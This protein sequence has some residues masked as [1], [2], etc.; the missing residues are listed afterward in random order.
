M[1]L[2]LLSIALCI[3]LTSGVVTADAAEKG[4]A[5]VNGEVWGTVKAEE[6]VGKNTGL[7]LAGARISHNPNAANK[8]LSDYKVS[9]SVGN[10]QTGNPPRAVPANQRDANA[11]EKPLFDQ[12]FGAL[13]ALPAAK[14]DARKAAILQEAADKV[15]ALKQDKNAR[16]AAFTE[17]PK[18]TQQGNYLEA[19][20]GLIS[21]PAIAEAA[22]GRAKQ[23]QLGLAMNQR[24]ER[25]YKFEQEVAADV[26][27]LKKDGP[28]PSATA[29]AVN[30]DPL[31]VMWDGAAEYQVSLRDT[32]SDPSQPAGLSLKATAEGGGK[33]AA[34]Y[35]ADLAFKNFSDAAALPSDLLD[36]ES[37]ASK[38]FSLS[39]LLVNDG[40]GATK[41]ISL[42][43][44]AGVGIRDS[45]S[46]A[47]FTDVLRNLDT[48]TSIS[49]G[50]LSFNRD[51]SFTLTLP[52][53][54]A[55]SV[56]FTRDISVGAAVVP[57]P[58]TYAGLL[59][60]MMVLMM[61]RRRIAS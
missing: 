2:T 1:K 47:S 21:N 32:A 29:F 45:M 54:P 22:K 6:V 20:A 48:A 38:A 33:A 13:G 24:P 9:S 30:R 34:L 35:M 40:S 52:D 16:P 7:S 27:R 43:L 31:A 15:Y 49:N 5:A 50:M 46:G 60:G 17:L 61:M 51:F 58:A 42:A 25:K 26:N 4:A 53:A 23:T 55:G 39:I 36:L 11:T 3:S 14:T 37:S 10:P 18:G 28:V 44:G 57:E 41:S 19:T 8:A 56:L 59:A 12:A